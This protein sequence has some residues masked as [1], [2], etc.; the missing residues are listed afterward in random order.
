MVSKLHP[1]SKSAGMLRGYFTFI[2]QPEGMVSSWPICERRRLL[3]TMLVR[4]VDKSG[5]TQ[6]IIKSCIQSLSTSEP[7]TFGYV[8]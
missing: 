4:L 1:D 8:R 6:Q 2:P 3:R 7:L 5:C